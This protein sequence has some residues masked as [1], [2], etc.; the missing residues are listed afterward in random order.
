MCN[1]EKMI[2]AKA[3]HGT[4]YGHDPADEDAYYEFFGGSDPSFGQ[5]NGINIAIFRRVFQLLKSRNVTF[6]KPVRSLFLKQSI[7][8]NIGAGCV[9]QYSSER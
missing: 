8:E 6:E 5:T 4:F 9:G 3:R 1:W 2:A 7:N